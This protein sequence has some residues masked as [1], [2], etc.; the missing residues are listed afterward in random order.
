MRGNCYVYKK[1]V[2]WSLLNEGLSIPLDIQVVFQN[3]VK[4]F[5]RRGESKKISLVLDGIT[6]E[7]QLKNQV[8]DE[9]KYPTHKD[10]LQIR[11]TPNR[12]IVE[13]LRSVFFYSYNYICEERSRQVQ[14]QKKYVKIPEEKMEYLAIYTTEYEDTYLVECITCSEAEDARRFIVE[15]DEQRYEAS[16][17]YPARDPSAS[18]ET[19]QQLV[20]IRK[21][22]RAIGENL[23]LLYDYRCQICGDNFGKRFD[24]RIVESHHINP[25]VKSMNNDADNQIIIC[26]NHH[27]LIH[28][29]EPVFQRN[30]LLLVYSN[31][32]TEQ[33]LLNAH[34]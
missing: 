1:E 27:R 34:L 25:F 13:K 28:R 20:K 22:N 18:I 26:P 16:I 6:Y 9:A 31:G 30:N 10:I 14:K 17:N 3:N 2:D 12:T 23:K 5:I 15:E 19:I 32:V 21:L 33:I 24:S 11:Y 29:A 7:V 4:K 8:F